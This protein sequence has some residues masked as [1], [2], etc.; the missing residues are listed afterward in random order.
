MNMQWIR[1]EVIRQ[2]YEISEHALQECRDEDITLEVLDHVLLHG[3]ILEKY[4]EREDPRGE[5]CLVLGHT[6][7]GDPVHVVVMEDQ[8]GMK[9][10]TA[11][12]PKP[13]KWVDERTRRKK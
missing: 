11:Y 7:N 2:S 1:Q 9:V 4:E 13:P 3:E 12:L 8:D 5:R 6:P 10:V